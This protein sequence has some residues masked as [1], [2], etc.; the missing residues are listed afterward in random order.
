M[1]HFYGLLMNKLLW[2]CIRAEETRA[3]FDLTKLLECCDI[4]VEEYELL[5]HQSNTFVFAI[6]CSENSPS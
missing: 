6:Y 3:N 5:W 2:I 1:K 4:K